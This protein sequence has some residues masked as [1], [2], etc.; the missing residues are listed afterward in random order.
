MCHVVR[1]TIFYSHLRVVFH[2]TGGR[3]YFKYLNRQKNRYNQTYRCKIIVSSSTCAFGRTNDEDS[4]PSIL[5][6]SKRLHFIL[7]LSSFENISY[8]RWMFDG[9]GIP[10]ESYHGGDLLRERAK[11]KMVR[12]GRKVLKC[13]VNG[14]FRNSWYTYYRDATSKTILFKEHPSTRKTRLVVFSIE[15]FASGLKRNTGS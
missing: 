5:S 13:R 6:L 9:G 8:N 12:K 3:F 15:K 1:F 11:A 10:G 14:T 4:L 7:V 2:S